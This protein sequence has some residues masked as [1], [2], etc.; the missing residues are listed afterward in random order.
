MGTLLLTIVFSA[1]LV[2]FLSPLVLA[3][4]IPFTHNHVILTAGPDSGLAV[5]P[6]ISSYSR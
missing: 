4:L 2:S 6:S 1:L 3:F 5:A